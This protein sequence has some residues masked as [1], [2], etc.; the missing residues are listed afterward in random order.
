VSESRRNLLIL[1]LVLGLAAAA[2]AGVVAKGFTQGLDLKGGLEVVLKAQPRRGQTVTPSILNEAASVMRKRIDPNGV[3]QPE[4]RTS[5]ADNTIEIALPGVKDPNAVANLLTAGQLLNFDFFRY[6]NKVSWAG[7]Q[8]YTTNPVASAYDL[9]TKADKRYGKTPKKTPTAWGLFGAKSHLPFGHTSL[10][11][12]KKQVLAQAHRKTQPKGTVWLYVPNHTLA[13]SCP[14]AV[15]KFCWG[16]QSTTGTWWYLFNQP[17]PDQVV[18][19]DMISSASSTTDQSGQPIVQINYKGPGAQNFLNLTKSTAQRS[20][21]AG[22]SANG[23]PNAIIVDN[24]LVSTPTVNPSQFYGGIDTRYSGQSSEITGVTKSEADRIALEIQSGTLPVTFTTESEQIVSATLGKDALHS[25]LIAGAA[26]LAFVLV[27]LLV[28]YGFLGLIA[29]LALIIYG[30]L[31]AGIV[32]VIPVTMTLPGIAGTILTIGVAADANIVIFERIKEEVRAGKT[33]RTA[34]ATGYRRGFHTITDAN[35][36]TLITA[37]VLY[38]SA[39]SSV[40]GFALMLLIGVITSIFT[41]VVATRAMLGTLSGFAF[42]ASS[43]VLGAV[44]TGDRWKKY[45]FIGRR[46]WWFALSG[47][48]LVAGAISMGARGLNEGIDFTGGSQFDFSTATPL[49]TGAMTQLVQPITGAD[50][51][52]RGVVGTHQT[53]GNT[54]THFQVQ[55]HFLQAGP[56]KALVQKLQQQAGAKDFSINSVSSSFGHSVLASAYLAVFFSLVIIFIYVSFRFEWTFAIPVM[57]ALGHDIL[58]TIGVYSLSGRAVTADTVAAVLTVLGY[59]MY[60]TVIVF[61]RVRENVPILRR[62]SASRIVNES[63]A[64]TITRSLN[65]SFVTLVPVVLLFIFGTGTLTDFAF[66]LIIG[67]VSGAYSSIFIAAPILAMLMERQPAFE[68]RRADEERAPRPA[69]P[70]VATATPSAPA[71]AVPSAGPETATTRRRRRR[72]HGRNR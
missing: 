49:S 42:M 5:T 71:P 31:L 37:A 35:V 15:T 12:T 19:G 41:A 26:G 52:V 24:Q 53:E 32:A 51:V 72:A 28:F 47:V 16:T 46:N 21:A 48:I 11:P 29:D 22:L 27:F 61:D 23:A 36:V 1:A 58:I 13:V 25:G 45:D 20:A 66:A 3:K 17:A 62:F 64:E 65:T 38:V 56:Q 54:F 40:K 57:V 30:L 68:K 55:S 50:A 60:D 70:A 34:I 39:T 67:V 33:I 9:L 18:T 43:R 59:S 7:N 14:V 6:L 8:P 2:V 4:V 44:G 63:L 10:L 69:A